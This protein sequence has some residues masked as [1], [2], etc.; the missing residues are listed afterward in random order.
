M[1]KNRKVILTS[2]AIILTLIVGA[3]FVNFTLANSGSP[4]K[5]NNAELS[6]STGLVGYSNI[7]L[8]VINSNNTGLQATG[9]DKY[10]ILQIL[11]KGQTSVVSA[12]TSLTAKVT[13]SG[14]K[15][16][17]KKEND[18]DNTSP[19]WKY[20]Y[21]GEYFRH[22]VFNGYKTIA[23][24]EMASGAVVL[25]TVTVD[26]LNKMD[27][28]AQNI[29]SEADFIYIVAPDENAYAGG[30]KDLNDSMVDWLDKYTTTDRH[31][32]VIDR[33]ALCVK[34]PSTIIGNNSSYRMGTFA[35]K[36]MTKDLSSRYNNV[37]VVEPGYFRT[38]YEEADNS[39][40][41]DPTSNTTKTIS[42]F[43]LTAE[44]SATEGG[45][46][47]I[48]RKR[49][50]KWYESD[51][52]Q[53]FFSRQS[54]HSDSTYV[55][56]SD[57]V[58]GQTA[59]RKSWD[60]DNA[61][62]LVISNGESDR[63]FT[64]LAANN[65]SKGMTAAAYKYNKKNQ[66]WESAE[67]ADNSAFTSVAYGNNY[68]YTPSGANIF[69]LQS[70]DIPNAITE[71]EGA[72]F[73]T[74]DLS[75][76]GFKDV[77]TTE[78]SGE[79]RSKID[80]SGAKVYLA[81]TVD[82]KTS[83]VGTSSS[84][85]YFV[86]LSS[87]EG[88]NGS[89]D[90]QTGIYT[91]KYSFPYL[92]A[93]SEYT[94][95][96]VLDVSSV[97]SIRALEEDQSDNDN[98]SDPGNNGSNAGNNSENSGNNTGSG[99]NNTGSGENNTGN[100]GDNTGNGENNTGNTANNNIVTSI[101]EI[102]SNGTNF[103]LSTK[104]EEK[105]ADYD[106]TA[107]VDTVKEFDEK[108]KSD[109]SYSSTDLTYEYTVLDNTDEGKQKVFN[110]VKKAYDSYKE[111]LAISTQG[112]TV[113]DFTKYDFIF[114][115][116]GAYK[117]EIGLEGYNA[118]RN[119]VEKGVYVIVSNKAGDGKG[120][121]NGGES[122]KD[123][124]KII[125][126]SPSARAIA[127]II[128]SGEYRTGSDNKYRVLEIQ[129]DYPIDLD[130]A[131]KLK[132]KADGEKPK[133][134]KRSDGTAI[135]GNYY[136]VPSD[137]Q[138]GKAKEELK[139]LTTEYYDY[140]LT[141]AKIAYAVEDLDYTDIILT[142]V[143]TEQLIGMTDDILATYDMVYIGGDISALDR[144]V[145][146][147]YTTSSKLGE[148]AT[149]D[150]NTYAY[151]LLPTFIMYYHTGAIS[152]VD[153]NG[154][155]G[156][157]PDRAIS[158]SQMLAAPYIGST[159]YTPTYLAENGNDLTKSV[160]DELVAF[161]NAGRPVIVS[162]EL[163]QAYDNM[164]YTDD[165]HQKLSDAQLLQG[166]WYNGKAGN[167]LERKN[168]YLDPSS[169]MY[170]LCEFIHTK[171][172]AQK[173]AKGTDSADSA[174]TAGGAIVWGYDPSA[175]KKIGYEPDSDKFDATKHYNQEG[176]Y[177]ENLYTLM[178][179]EKTPV[180]DETVKNDASKKTNYESADTLK[181][182]AVVPQDAQKKLLNDAVVASTK[183]VRVNLTTTPTEYS[184]NNPSTFLRTTNLS[185]QFI[186]SGTA[187]SY[188][189]TLYVDT[190]KNTT[191]DDADMKMSGTATTGETTTVNISLDEDYYGSAYWY[192]E[193]TDANDVVASQSTGICKIA[194]EGG[195][196]ISILQVQTMAEGQNATSWTATDTLY[197]DIAS[198]MA[199]KICKYNTYANQADFDNVSAQQYTVLGR[200]ENRFGIVNYVKDG[201]NSIV[202]GSGNTIPL[203]R[204]DWLSNLADSINQEY[205]V[206]LDMVVASA[207]KATFTTGDKKTDTYDCLDTWVEE[208]EKIEAGEFDH[209]KAE[210]KNMAKAQLS[211][212]NTKTAAVDAPKKALDDYIDGAIEALTQIADSTS[213]VTKDT[214][215][216]DYREF[217]YGSWS[218][219]NGV[220]DSTKL[221]L[222]KFMKKTGEYYYIYSPQYSSNS[223]V[224][225]DQGV[226]SNQYG[227]EWQ[228]LY[229]A[230]TKANDAKIVAKDVYNTYLRRSYGSSFMKKM[231]SILV[232][233]PSDSFGGF[234]VDLKQKTCEYILDYVSSGGDLFF[235]H[236]AMT[237]FADAGAVNL[238][239][240]LLSVVGMNRFHVDL[241]NQKNSYDVEYS[242]QNVQVKDKCLVNTVLDKDQTVYVQHKIKDGVEQGTLS[243][244]GNI[245]VKRIAASGLSSGTLKSSGTIYTKH[246]IK[247]GLEQGTLIN[248]GD[249]YV[250]HF[251]QNGLEQGTLKSDGDIYVKH[252]AESGLEYSKNISAGSTYY[253]YAG[254]K[255]LEGLVWGTVKAGDVVYNKKWTNGTDFSIGATKIAASEIYI[256]SDE[257][258]NAHPAYEDMYYKVATVDTQG[259]YLERA[260]G[261]YKTVTEYVDGNGSSHKAYNN[262]KFYFYEKTAATGTETGYKFYEGAK[263]YY[264]AD[265]KDHKGTGW[266]TKETG[267]AGDTGY[268]MITGAKE[269]TYASDGY[270]NTST[271][272]FTKESGK[273][274]DT[275][276]ILVENAESLTYDGEYGTSTG[277]FTKTTAPAG[278][279]GYIAY[280][281]TQYEYVN[282]Y[283]NTE[284][285]Y[286]SAESAKAGTSGY[287]RVQAS[288]YKYLTDV[289]GNTTTGY[290]TT[291]TGKKGD[292]GYIMT[293]GNVFA[294]GGSSIEFKSS[295]PLYYMTPY[296][297]NTA[298]GKGI[299][300]SMNANALDAYNNSIIGANNF[301]S[302][303]LKVYISGLA[304]TP[305]Y[306]NG[307]QGGATTN[308]PYVY[309]QEQFQQATSWSA[310]SNT[311]QSGVSQTIRARRLND[312]LVTMYPFAISDTLEIAGTHQQA[313]A[314]DLESSKTTVWYTL[315]G[316][317]NVNNAKSRSSLYAASPYD[318]MDSYYIYTTAYGK[319]AITYCGSGHSSV[320]GKTTNN[321]DERKLFINVIVN[322][323]DAVPDKPEITVYK[324]DGTFDKLL[325]TDETAS[326]ESGK[327]IYL[328]DSKA[329]TD[330]PTF[331][332]KVDFDEGTEPT[333]INIYYDLNLNESTYTPS[334]A[335]ATGNALIKSYTDDQ[336]LNA[337]K[338]TDGKSL[339]DLIRNDDETDLAPNDSYFT[340]YGGNYTYI[341]IEVYYSGST[342]PVNAI[343]KVKVSDPLFNLTQ[344]NTDSVV[345]VDG[346]EAKRYTF[347]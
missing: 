52:M 30:E 136:T 120:S 18:Y 170:D 97:R 179:G 23:N 245:Y 152:Q 37:L 165:S 277:Y 261:P 268:V 218:F 262:D 60:Y 337:L 342:K 110:Y 145:S 214:I 252:D 321:R 128:N 174:T 235:F 108:A 69:V 105:S 293:S 333:L 139:S 264:Y 70:K 212:L 295:N 53:T 292:T 3:V 45:D 173:S 177:G 162:N 250:K 192:L 208:A 311:D 288:E 213:G 159:Y 196:K 98:T 125:I 300:N 59:A 149:A 228:K 247:S 81:V 276:Y 222:L 117:D 64:T 224:T 178:S 254:D 313:Y 198:Q 137:V 101:Y 106:Y 271:G 176:Q 207:D 197:F 8:A 51:D 233:G 85:K 280:T 46:D 77:K 282:E 164:S 13:A 35:Y 301:N 186:V 160:Y 50:Y 2:V 7:D 335:G 153:Y 234:R 9:E 131:S 132:T 143:S 158:G 154:V 310:A 330:A 67:T 6:A 73:S 75:N 281:A 148:Q 341:V 66:T 279:S 175:T 71:Q 273:R 319:G 12:D 307:S 42:D 94:Y 90:E 226:L 80:L 325:G 347:A 332:Y 56:V 28:N 68:R 57:K 49:Y 17:I 25:T 72:V 88:G 29:L 54:T 190:N 61:N 243:A 41:D 221:E 181:C 266:F 188:K 202:D 115:E 95:S 135:T 19:L 267:K 306:Y 285:A 155:G 346:I 22:A 215:S 219:G 74:S 44:R 255:P 265:D 102:G 39:K 184:E 27:T 92:N 210:Y 124:N 296:A 315:A 113:V 91:Y 225:L 345:A 200:H 204:D 100:T 40:I 142:Q 168:Y 16:N 133:W 193:I 171:Y 274:G 150:G 216:A 10:H 227:A 209:T 187:A 140:D 47:Y 182:Y 206:N 31:P 259:Y 339:K 309:A 239:K 99:E 55:N 180:L 156:L 127:N 129:P 48:N 334:G 65:D 151:S 248:D 194:N 242:G 284:K 21:D 33:Y 123:D 305:L 20:V 79:V 338:S 195:S 76:T 320:T 294:V 126:N 166:Y 199:H 14:Y 119:A 217:L 323:A 270:G 304:M 34:D 163:S 298:Q 223:N 331:D 287:I 289:S 103:I 283:G 241:T 326:N 286:F 290:F 4:A 63:M 231:Y 302:K 84:E 107:P 329:K 317:N 230:Y 43:I 272:Y 236:D 263:S 104:G 109:T 312:G 11:P 249:I 299:L 83:Y 191:F 220:S 314:L 269:Y 303:N 327:T 15:G 240:S 147:L 24:Q 244:D 257:N 111:N 32:L 318:A 144:D 121:G 134:T 237:P 328:V 203:G 189:Y 38:L 93:G 122:G 201:T 58:T 138:T 258:G 256:K 118:L 185:Y 297:F 308:I 316:S 167:K 1:F 229:K 172:A 324:P 161:V 343:I 275:G 246:T 114:I 211:V 112:K 82:G 205:D 87:A 336:A 251:V 322:S 116:A 36:I 260:T 96:V 141:L 146:Q 344:N 130:V 253:E 340:P 86:K 183:R 62:V 157:K 26:T 238:T 291:T 278:T 78:V 5:E 232:L 89:K 169:R